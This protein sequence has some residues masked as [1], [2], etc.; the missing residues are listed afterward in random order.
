MIKLLASIVAASV[1]AGGVS[2]S[3][4]APPAS[5]SLPA[6]PAP[7]AAIPAIRLPGFAPW[8]ADQPLAQGPGAW[9]A[10]ADTAALRAITIAADDERQAGRWAYAAS[11]IATERGSDATGVLDIMAL[12]DPDLMLVTAWQRA[13][14]VAYIQA[15]HVAD[16]LAALAQPGL[17][18]DPES[19][20]WRMRALAQSGDSATALAQLGCAA[21]AF[22]ARHRAA[23]RPFII[24]AAT[25]ASATGRHRAVLSWLAALNDGDTMANLLRGKALLALGQGQEGRLRLARVGRLGTPAERADATLTKIE[26]ALA[27]RAIGPGAALQRLD[28]LLI[29]WRGDRIEERALRLSMRL[30]QQNGDALRELSSEAVLARYFDLGLAA[31]PLV[32]TLQAR[33]AILLA[34]NSKLPLAEAV[35]LFW[36]YRDF[37]PSGIEGQRMAEALVARLQ[38][39]GLYDRAADLLNH[40]LTAMTEQ[41]VEKGPLSIRIASLRI[42]AGE[43]EAAVRVIRATDATVFPADM[44]AQR[45]RLEA[46]A[47]D[48]L[49]KSREALAT[50]DDVPDGALIS[51]E[52]YWRARDWAR[53]EVAGEAVLPPSGKLN[54]VGQAIVLRQ[55]ITSAMLGHRDALAR[56]HARY[57]HAFANLPTAATFEMLSGNAD[58]VDRAALTRAM[59]ALPSASPAGA[60]GD[61]M[62]AGR[63]AIASRTASDKAGPKL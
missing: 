52:I 32:A 5:P 17:A 47:L 23:R 3:V 56:L 20:L 50:L 33:L 60:I 42:L 22:A 28:K 51:A 41:D 8:L 14:G 63:D 43:P 54:E 59:A 21:P 27:T 36:D 12:D 62:D 11:L 45:R 19:C 15:G 7:I 44:V 34:P 2:S 30:A 49:G 31:G 18:G 46:V 61:L 26:D 35:G 29:G 9:R 53:L 6:P 39:A 10:I 48:L 1:A 4:P 58:A 37:A 16:G 55:A 38:A 24:A 13:H 40:R 25:A 57:A